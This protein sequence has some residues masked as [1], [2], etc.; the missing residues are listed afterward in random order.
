MIG[1]TI[2]CQIFYLRVSGQTKTFFAF[3]IDRLLHFEDRYLTSDELMSKD[4]LLRDLR[5]KLKETS[6]N[7]DLMPIDQM[8]TFQLTIGQLASGKGAQPFVTPD[9]YRNWLVRLEGYMSG[10]PVQKKK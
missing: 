4:I 8:W 6:F 3:Y 5:L 1:T 2:V 7:K 10:C 9:D